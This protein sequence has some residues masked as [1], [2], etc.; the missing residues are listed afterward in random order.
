M[1]IKYFLL[2]LA[3]LGTS[4]LLGGLYIGINNYSFKK[5]AQKT[6]G[7]VVE[8]NRA[9]RGGLAPVVEYRTPDGVAHRYESSIFSS[10][11]AY[12]MNE[13]VVMYFDP[14]KPDEATI[15][16]FLED[17]LAPLLMGGIGGMVGVI[18][19]AGFFGSV[20]RKVVN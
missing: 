8:F 3:V 12:D 20:R 1:Q 6:T 11:P 13:A 18:G 10:P 15:G 19:W 14:K 5:N 9:R 16:G 2:I 7:Y 4:S 17:W